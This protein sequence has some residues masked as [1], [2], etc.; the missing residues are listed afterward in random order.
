MRRLV[1]AGAVIAAVMAASGSVRADFMS[2]DELY[3]ECRAARGSA[4]HAHCLGNITGIFEIMKGGTPDEFGVRVCIPPSSWIDKLYV[5]D[6]EEALVD[7]VMQFWGNHPDLERYG[8]T[9]PVSHAFAE[10]FPCSK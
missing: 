2:A 3:D 10:A 1:P 8:A 5:Q 6:G 4:D 9:I 7:I